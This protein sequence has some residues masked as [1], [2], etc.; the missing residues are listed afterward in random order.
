M[1]AN[2]CARIQ[3][4]ALPVEAFALGGVGTWRRTHDDSYLALGPDSLGAPA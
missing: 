1:P 2:P 3:R 4:V